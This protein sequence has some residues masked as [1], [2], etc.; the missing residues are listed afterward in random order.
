MPD[1]NFHHNI[2]QLIPEPLP[3]FHHFVEPSIA[4][5]SIAFLTV[6]L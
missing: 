6:T 2:N 5:V 4:A 3:Y 1:I